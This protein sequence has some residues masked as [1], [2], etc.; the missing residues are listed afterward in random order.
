MTEVLIPA[1]RG[2]AVRVP[3]GAAQRPVDAH[4]Q[5]HNNG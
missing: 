5:V 1:R 4:F 2:R 3:H